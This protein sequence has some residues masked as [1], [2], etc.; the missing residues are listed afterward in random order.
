MQR[1][2]IDSFINSNPDKYDYIVGVKG[3][4]L[5]GGQKQRIA[6]ARTNLAKPKI[7]ILDDNQSK[8]KYKKLYII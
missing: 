5:S 1:V 4:K 6:I 7:F 8:K 2:Y 3:K